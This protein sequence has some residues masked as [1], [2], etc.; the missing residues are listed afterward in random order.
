MT[1]ENLN[2]P[3]TTSE[4]SVVAVDHRVDLFVRGSDGS[5]RWKMGDDSGVSWARGLDPRVLDR[6]GQVDTKC[7]Y[8]SDRRNELRRNKKHSYSISGGPGNTVSGIMGART[9]GCVSAQSGKKFKSFFFSRSARLRPWDGPDTSCFSEPIAVAGSP[10]TLD[11]FTSYSEGVFHKFWD[12]R[13]WQ[14]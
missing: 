10:N 2:E 6:Q 11:V 1:W 9:I 14:P 5:L 4:L 8:F 3:N 13:A 12:G 7:S